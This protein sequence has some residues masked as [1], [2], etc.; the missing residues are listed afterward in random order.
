MISVMVPTALT[1]VATHFVQKTMILPLALPLSV[2]TAAGEWF[3][4]CDSIFVCL[5]V[6]V[7]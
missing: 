5:V 3:L 4:L 2:G 6:A 1:G 7:L